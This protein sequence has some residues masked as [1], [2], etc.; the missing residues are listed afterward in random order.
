[1]LSIQDYIIIVNVLYT[2]LKNATISGND[3]GVHAVQQTL[4]NVLTAVPII[5]EHAK[6]I[7]EHF[8]KN[9]FE[10]DGQAKFKEYDPD[11]LIS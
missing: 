5:T 7:Y 2:F 3:T 10:G 4:R 11:T 1:M 9:V 8:E 6:A